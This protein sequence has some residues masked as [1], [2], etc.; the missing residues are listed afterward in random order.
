MKFIFLN[1]HP[2]NDAVWIESA[3]KRGDVCIP[4]S[5]PALA[6]QVLRF[7]GRS[8]D[9]AIIRREGPGGEADES[10]LEM[11]ARLKQDAEQADLPV[12]V[13]SSSW[14]DADFIEHQNR[15]EGAHAYLK[16]P[17]QEAQLYAVLEQMFGA[18][19]RVG[20][21]EVLVDAGHDFLLEAVEAILPPNV[22]REGTSIR[23]EIPEF[24]KPQYSGGVAQPAPEVSVARK[25]QRVASASPSTSVNLEAEVES[26][27]KPSAPARAKTPAIAAP[28]KPSSSESV[29]DESN[30]APAIL[31]SET[32]DQGTGFSELPR[33]QSGIDQLLADSFPYL[34]QSGRPKSPSEVA[35]EIMKHASGT[36]YD[37]TQPVGDAVVPGGAHHVLDI[38]TLRKYLFLREQDVAAL[39]TQL[40]AIREQMEA[41]EA[42]LHEEKAR[43]AELEHTITEQAGRIAGFD[44]ERQE[45]MDRLEAR[46]QEE[47]EE[48]RRRA[49]EARVL[50]HRVKE[51]EA[52]RI[53]L[54]R[55]VRDDLIRAVL[56]EREKS[57][58]HEI[59]KRDFEAQL[60]SRMN[61]ITELKRKVDTLEFNMD[62]AEERL[63]RE[64]ENNARL[65]Q[66]HAEALR[67]LRMAGGFLQTAEAQESSETAAEEGD[68]A[69]ATSDDD[70]GF[71][72]A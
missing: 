12:I 9:F 49:E 20:A 10:G 68:G 6:A 72:V 1:P 56:R 7:H 57:N 27:Q 13:V 26:P 58:R 31:N 15:P 22:R 3:R 53:Q 21:A 61:L 50:H 24:P 37:F 69:G 44:R 2:G 66:K 55:R 30:A 16:Y 54:K 63:Q 62:L 28:E 23:M 64:K 60:A 14:G 32:L 36:A 34:F 45:E 41:L 17:F 25:L 19:L 46:L 65:K 47:R 51:A 42:T 8:V 48:N 5:T 59:L 38:D 11:L 67:A 35:A 71:Q 33:E 70:S 18:Q 4:V 43:N 40:K 52:D 29:E 39:S